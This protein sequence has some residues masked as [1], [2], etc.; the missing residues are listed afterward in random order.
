MTKFNCG[1][2]LLNLAPLDS[3]IDLIGRVKDMQLLDTSQLVLC[4]IDKGTK[5][6]LEYRR[7][8]LKQLQSQ[9]NLVGKM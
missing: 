9:V 5:S 8:Q 6:D 1:K 3:Y 7:K 2:L 4:V